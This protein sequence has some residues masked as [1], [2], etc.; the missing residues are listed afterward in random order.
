MPLQSVQF[1]RYCSIWDKKC[2]LRKV[3]GAGGASPV[4]STE[5]RGV[6]EWT[7]GHA[8]PAESTESRRDAER[9]PRC[10]QPRV[11][12]YVQREKIVE[13]TVRYHFVY[14]RLSPDA[15]S[16]GSE[17]IPPG[18]GRLRNKAKRGE[19]LAK[20]ERREVRRG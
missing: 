19:I 9:W 12:E 5:A 8:R 20:V 6:L 7:R 3:R 2:L 18:L 1:R 13:K 10:W 16:D 17:E 15:R 11:C 14:N 4:L